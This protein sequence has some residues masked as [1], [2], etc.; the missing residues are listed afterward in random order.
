M[1]NL[2]QRQ[3]HQKQHRSDAATLYNPVSPIIFEGT[4]ENE[5]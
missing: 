5:A 2:H 1:W 3:H 4:P